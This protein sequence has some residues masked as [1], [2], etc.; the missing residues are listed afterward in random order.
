VFT[1]PERVLAL[2]DP[3]A[4]AYDE[5]LDLEATMKRL[6]EVVGSDGAA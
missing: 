5:E 4:G 2:G 6:G 1:V 3:M